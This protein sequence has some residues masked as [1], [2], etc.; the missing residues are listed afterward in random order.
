MKYTTRLKR[1]K[2]YNDKLEN[3]NLDLAPYDLAYETMNNTIKLL[4]HT[5]AYYEKANVECIPFTY[6]QNTLESYMKG[7]ENE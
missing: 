3:P 7:E 4:Q 1:I 5:R 2:H 6:A